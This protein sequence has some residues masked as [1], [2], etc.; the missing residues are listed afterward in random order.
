[1]TL[2]EALTIANRAYHERRL[3]HIEPKYI[4]DLRDVAEYIW[5]NADQLRR[6]HKLKE[7][8]ASAADLDKHN[9]LLEAENTKLE[10]AVA[11]LRDERN[12][13]EAEMT[14]KNKALADLLVELHK[15]KKAR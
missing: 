4:S 8:E 10:E 9:D 12:K 14:E 2:D 1:M 7:V 13:L 11:A 15:L 6:A 3:T 5:T